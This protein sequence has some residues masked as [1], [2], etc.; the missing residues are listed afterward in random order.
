MA[1]FG[2][3]AHSSVPAARTCLRPRPAARH[4]QGP[5]PRRDGAVMTDASP[6]GFPRVAILFHRFGPYHMSRLS[7]A[8]RHMSVIGV[9]FSG[10]DRTYEWDD[11]A[12][13]GLF[14]RVVVSPDIERESIPALVGKIAAT[15]ERAA[16]DAV[17]IA[18]WSHPAALAALL[19][20]ARTGVP[21]I[22]MSDSAEIDEIRKPWREAIKRRVIRLF[23]AGLVAGVPHRRYLTA[24][25]MDDT[26]IR[27]GF[28]V[29][30]N[31]YF[32]RSAANARADAV[33]VR[34]ELGLNRP[35]FLAS[36][37]FVAKKNLFNLLA[38]YRH[39]RAGA[40]PAAWDLVLLGGGPLAPSLRSTIEAE[41]LRTSVHLPGFRQYAELHRYYGLAGAFI[42]ASTSE[43]WGLVVN[44]AMAAGLPVLVSD[45]CGCSED[46][47][48]PGFNGYRFDPFDPIELG[49]QMCKIAFD[50]CD[51]HAMAQAG[52]VLIAD[53]S[54]DR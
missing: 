50:G 28:D 7:A 42:L 33:A 25:G 37:R 36:C 4:F 41:G 43:Q 27:E 16:P 12:E 29:V 26:R 52:Q 11:V 10:T 45:R 48:R 1:A 3:P 18:G 17:A 19:W 49:E 14:P 6:A 32:A 13:S 51:R 23:S 35:F 39:Y 5:S 21:A 8:S 31:D 24:L 15:L 20:C 9:E 54:P 46:L 44:E 2:L 40:G 47:V 30:D 53:W 38:A 22:L 34:A